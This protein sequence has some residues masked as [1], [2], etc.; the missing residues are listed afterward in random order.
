M[1]ESGARLRCWGRWESSGRNDPVTEAPPLRLLAWTGAL[2]YLVLVSVPVSV[3][4]CWDWPSAPFFR[5]FT[6]S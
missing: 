3:L 1:R 5:G 6:G 2:F 4:G